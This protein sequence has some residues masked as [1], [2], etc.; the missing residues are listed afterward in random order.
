ML[1]LSVHTLEIRLLTWPTLQVDKP[2]LLGL[3]ALFLVSLECGWFLVSLDGSGKKL[4]G[5]GRGVRIVFWN[6]KEQLRDFELSLHPDRQRAIT[7]AG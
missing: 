6:I 2:W 1:E 5:P 7:R 4:N 3:L